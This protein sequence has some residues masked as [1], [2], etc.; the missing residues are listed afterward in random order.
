MYSV[1]LSWID[2][3]GTTDKPGFVDTITGN[4]ST[5]NLIGI[6]AGVVGVTT[7]FVLIWRLA[8]YIRRQILAAMTNSKA[9]RG[10]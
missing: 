9:R 10:Y 8:A 3:T 7:A 5:V 6:L 2:F 4:F 1:L